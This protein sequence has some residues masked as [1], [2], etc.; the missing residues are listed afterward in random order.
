MPSEPEPVDLEEVAKE[1]EQ[2]DSVENLLSKLRHIQKLAKHYYDFE[3]KHWDEIKE[4]EI[5][6]FLIVPLLLALGWK[7]EQ[8]KIELSPSGLGVGDGRKSID[9]ACFSQKYE[10]NSPNVNKGSCSLILESKRFSSG[11]TKDAPDQAREY[12]RE[13][14]NCKTI[15]VSNGYCYKAFVREKG[16]FSDTPHAYLNLLKPTRKYPLEPKIGGALQ[17]LELLK[18]ATHVQRSS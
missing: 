13:F 16:E 14:P 10:K 8:I 4:H 6:T 12:A 1:L 15:V 9:I 7:E 3:Y 17:M 2:W 11:I 5:R 18:G